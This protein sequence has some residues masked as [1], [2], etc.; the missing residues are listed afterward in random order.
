MLILCLYSIPKQNSMAHVWKEKYMKIDRQK[1]MSEIYSFYITQFKQVIN[2]FF[3][4]WNK[5]KNCWDIAPPLTRPKFETH[6]IQ[7]FLKIKTKI[8]QDTFNSCPKSAYMSKN[9]EFSSVLTWLLTRMC[10]IET[11]LAWKMTI[12][13]TFWIKYL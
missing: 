7:I 5:H 1:T 6:G 4:K 10:K 12:F 13:T 11:R 9:S 3:S 8:P 2:V